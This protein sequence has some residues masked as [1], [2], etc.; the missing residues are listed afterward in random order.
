MKRKFVYE[1]IIK[2]L[3][4]GEDGDERKKHKSISDGR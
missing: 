3:R 2:K 1:N 4:R